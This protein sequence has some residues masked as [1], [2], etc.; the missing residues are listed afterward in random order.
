MLSSDVDGISVAGLVGSLRKGA[1]NR[2]LM[3]AARLRAPGGMRID[4]MEGLGDI[5]LFNEDLEAN[6]GPVA[7]A[8]LCDAIACADALLIATP[9]YN[10]SMPGTLKNL[11]DWLSRAEPSALDGKPLALMGASSGPWGT[12]LAQA[13]LRQTLIACGALIMPTPQLYL[14]SAGDAFDASGALVDG[15]A[16]GQLDALL[17]ALRHWTFTTNPRFRERTL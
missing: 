15:R 17:A 4:I 2:R 16:A 11:I 14:R 7:V 13:A 12:R 9:E 8:R 10:Q 6:G 1:F 5:P 3:E